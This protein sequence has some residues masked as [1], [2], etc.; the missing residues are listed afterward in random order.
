MEQPCKGPHTLKGRCLAL[1]GSIRALIHTDRRRDPRKSPGSFESSS[2]CQ[3]HLT[4][5]EKQCS[6]GMRATHIRNRT[7]STDSINLA[8]GYRSLDSSSDIHFLTRIDCILECGLLGYREIG[9]G[10]SCIIAFNRS[11]KDTGHDRN[12]QRRQ[13][14]R[15]PW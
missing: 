13:C 15:H 14:V 7:T 4:T 12:E 6:H 3:E 11:M 1:H 9:C 10:V 5:F 8:I 2:C